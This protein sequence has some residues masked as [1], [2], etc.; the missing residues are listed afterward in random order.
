MKY[1]TLF[2]RVKYCDTSKDGRN[3]YALIKFKVHR[4]LFWN[5]WYKID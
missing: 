4:H 3:T 5:I 2:F 1:F